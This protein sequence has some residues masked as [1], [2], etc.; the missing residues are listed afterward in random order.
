MLPLRG[1]E[2]MR[3]T[4]PSVDRFEVVLL[5]DIKSDDRSFQTDS[6]FE[7]PLAPLQTGEQC[8][9]PPWP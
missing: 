6:G 4:Y 8:Q 5:P 1:S 9:L 7:L 2:R 3:A